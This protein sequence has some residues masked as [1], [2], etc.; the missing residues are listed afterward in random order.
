MVRHRLTMTN[1]LNRC[2]FISIYT[3]IERI[4]PFSL[5]SFIPIASKCFPPWGGA[6]LKVSE[7]HKDM[8]DSG[9]V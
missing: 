4:S 6:S 3:R 2:N 7:C 1:L 9:Y 5:L 8:T